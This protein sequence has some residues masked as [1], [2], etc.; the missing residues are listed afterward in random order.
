MDFDRTVLKRRERRFSEVIL[1]FGEAALLPLRERD[2]IARD[3]VPLLRPERIR[4]Q[5]E[6]EIEEIL[7]IRL[8][9]AVGG[10]RKLR[11][12]AGLD[13]RH[14]ESALRHDFAVA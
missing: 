12:C 5:A 2:L 13:R 6:G 1:R 9:R 4:L 8:Q 11:A 14:V 7:G 3:G 10:P